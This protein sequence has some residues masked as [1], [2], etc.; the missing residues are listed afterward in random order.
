MNEFIY[1]AEAYREVQPKYATR[2]TAEA[3]RRQQDADRRVPRN[4]RDHA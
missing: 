4:T 2:S 3:P 1:L